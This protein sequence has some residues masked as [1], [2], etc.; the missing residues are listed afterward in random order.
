MII[1]VVACGELG[2]NVN[3]VMRIQSLPASL[4]TSVKEKKFIGFGIGL[5]RL[6]HIY[7][8]VV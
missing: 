5:E 3:P 1:E 4:P 6:L 2:D 8:D 7:N